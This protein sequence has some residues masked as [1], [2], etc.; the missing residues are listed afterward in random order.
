MK[1]AAVVVTFNRRALLEKTLAALDNQT[2]PLDQILIINNASTDD[3]KEFLDSLELKTPSRIVHERVNSGGAGGFSRG[4]ELAFEAGYD[5]FWLM[6]DDTVPHLD[7][8]EHLENGVIEAREYRGKTPSFSCSSVLWTDGNLCEMNT[9]E[10]TWDWSRP[11]VAGKPWIDVKSC[12]FVSCMVSREA[13][14][15]MGLPYKEYFIW[16]DDAEYTTRLSKYSPGIYVPDSKVDHL[17]AQNR[18]V[19]FGDV[20]DS[21]MWKFSRG[22]RN[23]VSGAITLRSLTLLAGL[24]ENMI[25]QMHGSGVSRKNRAKLVWCAAKGLVFRPRKRFPKTID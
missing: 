11:L 10:P 6:D 18:G 3:T 21:N 8:L 23:Q 2:R 9:P 15:A 13:A 5:Q 12:S 1:I 20:N 4:I 7:A 16:F 25:K 24:A 14:A 17:L 22:V 19:N